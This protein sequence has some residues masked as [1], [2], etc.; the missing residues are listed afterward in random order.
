MEKLPRNQQLSIIFEDQ[1]LAR[2]TGLEK[3][4]EFSGRRRKEKKN[5]GGRRGAAHEA[6]RLRVRNF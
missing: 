3:I 1:T 5:E 4:G 2:S 6:K